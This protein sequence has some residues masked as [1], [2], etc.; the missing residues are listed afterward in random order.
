MDDILIGLDH[1][2]STRVSERSWSVRHSVHFRAGFTI[3]LVP[4]EVDWRHWRSGKGDHVYAYRKMFLRGRWRNV[5]LHRLLTSAQAGCVVDHI[6]D[7]GLN[8]ANENL[9]VCVHRLNISNSRHRTNL[10]GFRGVYRRPEGTFSSGIRAGG[11]RYNLGTFSTVEE[12]ARA[13]D[14]AAIEHFGEFARLNFQQ[15]ASR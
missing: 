2:F 13:Y 8:N 9:R 12:A 5:F 15:Q 4:C 1:G 10:T 14:A 7:D 3:E 6:D 11:R